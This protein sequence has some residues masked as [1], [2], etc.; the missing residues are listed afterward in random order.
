MPMASP[1]SRVH[2]QALS[3]DCLRRPVLAFFFPSVFALEPIPSPV[4]IV[5]KTFSPAL[6]LTKR[7]KGMS[8]T[9]IPK[10]ADIS[11][12][13]G[14]GTKSACDAYVCLCRFA[15]DEGSE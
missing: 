2:S 5:G 4:P 12:K 3:M 7:A 11:E 15:G 8:Q 13:D 14:P 1:L 10:K 9:Q 6:K